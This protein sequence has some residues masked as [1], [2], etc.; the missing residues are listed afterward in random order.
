MALRPHDV[1]MPCH[2]HV[3]EVLSQENIRAVMIGGLLLLRGVDVCVW[4]LAAGNQHKVRVAGHIAGRIRI[5]G[6][7]KNGKTDTHA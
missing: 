7:G 6:Q 2:V 3:E 4:F 1:V 5:T